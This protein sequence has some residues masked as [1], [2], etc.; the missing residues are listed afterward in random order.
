MEL[1]ATQLPGAVSGISFITLVTQA[2]IIVKLVMLL[3]ALASVWCWAV[4]IEKTV[5]LVSLRRKSAVFERAFW[6]G[7]PLEDLYRKLG[8]REDHPMA[9]MFVSAIEE[10][11]ESPKTT[12]LEVHRRLVERVGK[13]MDVTMEREI[14][15]LEN[16]LS[17]LATIGSTAP[18]VGL[19]G[20]VWGIMRSFQSIA[21]T[22]NTTLAVVA[23]G[24][25][26]ALLATALGLVAAI[27]AV[28]AYNRLSNDVNN[29]GDR[30]ASFA[31]EF[32]IVLSR[33]TEAA[34]VR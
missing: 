26:E 1:T 29:F 15:R 28:V 31:D 32:T 7:T 23:P 22:N 14:Q 25:A 10:W 30:L 9:T 27:P 16:N 2:D 4:I 13:V 20:T 34:R 19:F 18:F 5:R 12:E 24:I 11:K 21:A 33:E 3:L 8:R 17:S 6:S